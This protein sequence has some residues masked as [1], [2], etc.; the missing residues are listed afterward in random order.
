MRIG[1]YVLKRPNKLT[2]QGNMF[3]IF[4]LLLLIFTVHS[5]VVHVYTYLGDREYGA[6]LKEQQSGTMNVT[7]DKVDK[8]FAMLQKADAL[9]I[10][11]PASLQR[12]LAALSL[13]KNDEASASKYLKSM[14]EK[15]PD[16]LEGR[17]K[18]GKLLILQGKN[19]KRKFN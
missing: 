19:Q 4:M 1:H 2:F 15:L 10:W 18:Y 14:L 9:G 7:S 12:E 11:H 8:S 16:D 5:A 17:L 13:L 6:L 3:S